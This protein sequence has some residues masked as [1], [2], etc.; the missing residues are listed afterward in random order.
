ML[1]CT[2]EMLQFGQIHR[3]MYTSCDNG[4]IN[5]KCI[6]V[7][8]VLIDHMIRRKGQD[9]DI[10]SE[11]VFCASRD[12]GA[13]GHLKKNPTKKHH[14]LSKM[15]SAEYTHT[16]IFL[17]CSLMAVHIASLPSVIRRKYIAQLSKYMTSVLI[18]TFVSDKLDNLDLK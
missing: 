12:S 17:N 13:K 4:I 10:L 18:F 15:T 6:K 5:N 3:V 14:K 16:H 7:K 11:C 2:R 1:G 9:T 8:R